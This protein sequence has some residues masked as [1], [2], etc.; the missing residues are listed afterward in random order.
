[1][2]NK[3]VLISSVLL[4]VLLSGCAG[5]SSTNIIPSKSSV[6]FLEDTSCIAIMD[7]VSIN[8]LKI[9]EQELYYSL[10]E[11]LI[12]KNL[13]NKNCKNT[14]YIKYDII[15]HDDVVVLLILK[16]K[17]NCAEKIVYSLRLERQCCGQRTTITQ[18]T[19]KEL[20]KEF[21]K[22][23]LKMLIDNKLVKLP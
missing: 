7:D 10:K 20:V 5:K 17:N 1:M 11:T 16:A 8:K 2:K 3:L 9:V 22:A 19:T 23:S 6:Y 13:Y 21:K 15:D 12:N 14:A 18:Y 4:V